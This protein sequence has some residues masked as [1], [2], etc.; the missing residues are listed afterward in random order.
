MKKEFGGSRVRV[1]HCS[2]QEYTDQKREEMLFSTYIEYWMDLNNEKSKMY[3]TEKSNQRE[4][5]YLKDWHLVQEIKKSGRDYCAYVTPM[6]FQ[7][8]WMNFY[9]DTIEGKDDYRFVYMGPKGT[10]T[11]LHADVF[12]SYS[13]S[14]N[15][16]GRKKW[17]LFSPD[18]EE[19]LRDHY[20][21]YI[22]DVNAVNLKQFPQFS[23]TRP[24]E[25]IQEAGETIF[26]PSG[27]FHEVWNLED[28]ISINHNW[29]FSPLFELQL[30][31]G[32]G[33]GNACNLDLFWEMLKKDLT[34]IEKEISDCKG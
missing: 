6:Y 16:C 9:W 23:R 11:P 5:L 28:T 33:K 10:W 18:Q 2:V 32:L 30:N 21:N 34:L 8:D 13:W 7:D 27:W 1:A 20:N 3:Q 25:I 15:I 29:V 14:T 24:L 4:L 12:R 26:I 19:L 22:Y 31:I 17:L